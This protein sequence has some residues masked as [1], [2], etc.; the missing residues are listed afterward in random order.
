[1]KVR[2]TEM[3]HLVVRVNRLYL[4]ALNSGQVALA[5]LLLKA[6]QTLNRGPARL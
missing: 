5:E 4:R 6:A 3:R 1:M 2:R